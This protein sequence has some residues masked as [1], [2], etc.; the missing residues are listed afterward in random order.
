M[1]NN[2][3][4]VMRS[5]RMPTSDQWQQIGPNALAGIQNSKFQ[6]YEV[7]DE[8][9]VSTGGTFPQQTFVIND[10]EPVEDVPNKISQ[11]LETFS[12]GSL[13][14]VNCYANDF[15][16]SI[17]VAPTG[18]CTYQTFISND[19]NAF[20]EKFFIEGSCYSLVRPPFNQRQNVNFDFELVNDGIAKGEYKSMPFRCSQKLTTDQIADSIPLEHNYGRCNTILYLLYKYYHNKEKL[21]KT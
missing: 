21:L 5:D 14:P 18:V 6:V 11:I 9:V 8:G 10:V 20:N 12:C 19:G 2:E 15:P 7:P 4:I 17:T 13:V 1:S 3:R 16:D